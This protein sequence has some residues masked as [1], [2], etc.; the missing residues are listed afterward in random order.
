MLCSGVVCVVSGTSAGCA[1]L[2]VVTASTQ[3]GLWIQQV[4]KK[5][6]DS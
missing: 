1:G 3:T 5:Q 4:C 6:G 2:A